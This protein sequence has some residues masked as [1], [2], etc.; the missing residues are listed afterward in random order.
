MIFNN[1]K[2]G[3]ALS[4]VIIGVIGVIIIVV[5]VILFNSEFS[6][7]SDRYDRMYEKDCESV[8]GECVPEDECLTPASRVFDESMIECQKKVDQYEWKPRN[9]PGRKGVTFTTIVGTSTSDTPDIC[10]LRTK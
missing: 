4:F 9:D 6:M 5:L 2:K 8:G 3:L 7:F 10:C 1:S